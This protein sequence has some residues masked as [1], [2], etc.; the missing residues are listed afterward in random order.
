MLYRKCYDLNKVYTV[1]FD[2]F[3]PTTTNIH[4]LLLRSNL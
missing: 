1:L 4:M 3:L 2:N